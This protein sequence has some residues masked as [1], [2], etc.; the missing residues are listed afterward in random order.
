MVK[1]LNKRLAF[2]VDSMAGGGAERVM[3]NLANEYV[4]HGYEVDLVLA[5]KEGEYLSDVDQKIRIVDINAKRFWNYF[6]PLIRYFRNEK[7][8][9]MLTATTIINIIAIL[10]RKLAGSS[11][12]LVVSE[13]I[14]I[15]SIAQS[16]A[17]QRKNLVKRLIAYCYPKADAIV[18]VSTGA[19]LSLKNFSGLS[20][21]KITTIYNGVIDQQKLNLSEQQVDHPWFGV[22]QN[23]EPVI[24]SVGRLQAQKDYPTLLKAFAELLKNQSSKLLILGEGELRSE[25]EELASQLQISE[26]VSFHGF[27]SNPFKYLANADAF[28]LSSQFE[29]LPTVLIEALACGCPVVSTRCPSGPEEILEN[30]KYG[31]LVDVEDHA[32]LAGALYDTLNFEPELKKD[33]RQKRIEHGRKFD[34]ETAFFAYSEVLGLN[35]SDSVIKSDV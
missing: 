20:E 6:L 3:L 18:A 2:F 21:E 12:R 5:R 31:K 16:G 14:D 30:G 8:A 35:S 34:V 23:K 28:V 4:K 22:Q 19:A 17:L 29:G 27:E 9:V 11:S 24:V 32:A 7:P 25:L 33:E 10:S 1:A 15:V 26:A 13:H